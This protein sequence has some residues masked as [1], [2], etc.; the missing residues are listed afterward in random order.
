[1]YDVAWK[2]AL[3][4]PML[5]L[6]FYRINSAKKETVGWSEGRGREEAKKGIARRVRI[7]LLARPILQQIPIRDVCARNRG[8]AS[9]RRPPRF[10]V[11]ADTDGDEVERPW[12]VLPFCMYESFRNGAGGSVKRLAVHASL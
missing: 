1:M 7:A 10:A 6:T 9:P 3:M 11:V 4:T 8:D 2:R 12:P 5:C